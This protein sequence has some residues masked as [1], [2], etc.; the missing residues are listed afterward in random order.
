LKAACHGALL[1]A[2]CLVADN[3]AQGRLP[4]LGTYCIADFSGKVV[5][6]ATFREAI[7]AI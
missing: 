1:N 6:E 5:A 2:R 7:E 4:E 3:I